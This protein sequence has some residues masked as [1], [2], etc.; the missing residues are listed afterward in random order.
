MMASR[1]TSPLTSG[2]LVGSFDDILAP[3]R[4]RVSVNMAADLP[5]QRESTEP[6]TLAKAMRNF[7]NGPED[8]VERL[9]FETDPQLINQFQSV[10]RAKLKLLP[11]GLIKRI[12]IQDDLVAAIV[13]AR[14]TQMGAFG[15]P[16]PDRFSTGFVIESNPGVIERM[17]PDERIEL[18]KRIQKAVRAF[19]TCGSTENVPKKEY[20][21]FSQYLQMTTRNAVGLGRIAT[22]IIYTEPMEGGPKEFHHFR[23]T[24]AGTIYKA[25]AQKSAAQSV[26]DQALKI[27]KQL[28]G[29]SS[30]IRI[31]DRRFEEDEYSWIQVIDARPVQAFTDDQMRVHNF[32]QVL[33][34][35]LDGYPV[36]PI[37]TMISAVTTHINITTHNK[38]YFQTGRASR[39]MLVF[40]SDDVD[41]HTLQRVKQQFNASINSVNNAWRMPVFSCGSQDEISWEPIDNSSRDAEF[42]YLTDMN[43]RV[44][45]SAFQ[46]SPDELPG[47]AYLSRGTN[48]Q[49]LSESNNEYR[50][51]AARDQGIRPLMTQFEDFINGVLFPL[52]DENLSKI[53]KFKLKGLDADTEEKEAQRL[54]TNMPVHMTPDEVLH[55]VEKLPLG[56]EW[57]GE[58]LLNPQWQANVD[59]YVYVDEFRE[60]FMG[61]PKD[62]GLHYLRDPFYFQWLQLQAQMQQAQQP[63]GGD[64]GGGGDAGGGDSGGDG[65]G[66]PKGASD[67]GGSKSDGAAA[68]EQQQGVQAGQQQQPGEDLTR[69]IDQA[70]QVLTKSEATLPMSKRKL[71][72]QH[73]LTVDR[74]RLGMEN[75]IREATKK[76]LADARKHRS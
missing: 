54:I 11:D 22:E 67:G 3:S 31:D 33:D 29:E 42:Q 35:E 18:S 12:L 7:L 47:W 62:P 60:H 74:I 39:G 24:D 6:S 27:L 25:Q 50:M 45:L 61:L 76:I 2:S 59:K 46:M 19:W 23:P 71:L 66:P 21:S 75:D 36:T 4:K 57:C 73:R 30:D 52:I 5:V 51:E 38:I 32:F 55:K 40:K 9:A 48:N 1:R 68:D 28:K 37:D 65:G 10:Y 41:E 69:S 14:E 15:R 49:S 20:L 70:I 53:C 8:S 56:K 13:R 58:I 63:G 16:R 26:R 72:A 44:I 64:D 17:A 43:A 34:V